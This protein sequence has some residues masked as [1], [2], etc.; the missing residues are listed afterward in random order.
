MKHLQ[1]LG[2]D[3]SDASMYWKYLPTADVIINGTDE[4]EEE[5]CLFVSQPN[6]KYKYPTYTFTDIINKLPRYIIGNCTLYKLHIEPHFLGKWIICYEIG[7]S[8]SFVFK[9][10]DNLID[11]AYEML[12]WCIDNGYIGNKEE[13]LKEYN[14]ING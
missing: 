9:D 11:A 10:S 6:M 7:I 4:I 1:K 8:K 5:P 12:C 14:K 2:L 3:T 13:F